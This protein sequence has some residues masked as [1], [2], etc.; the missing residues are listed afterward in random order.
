[1]LF[2][3]AHIDKTCTLHENMIYYDDAVFNSD[4]T[5]TK[6]EKGQYVDLR[7]SNW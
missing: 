1:M 2:E 6:K 3:A 5:K 7:N 4:R